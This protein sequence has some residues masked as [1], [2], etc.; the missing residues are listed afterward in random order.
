MAAKRR[1]RDTAQVVRCARREFDNDDR[2]EIEQKQVVQK[3]Q[4]PEEIQPL[5]CFFGPELYR[6]LDPFHLRR[7]QEAAAGER[8][9]GD[10]EDHQ[11]QTDTPSTVTDEAARAVPVI[12][13]RAEEARDNEEGR[14]AE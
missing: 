5:E 4:V 7:Q 14:H 9:R 1:T 12:K 8:Q 13:E 6:K 2:G 3:P 10:E 11:R